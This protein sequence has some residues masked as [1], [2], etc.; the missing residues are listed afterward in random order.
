MSLLQTL[1]ADVE[2]AVAKLRTHL[3]EL[4]HDAEAEATALVEQ[5]KAAAGPVIQ[6][7]ED[8]AHDLAAEAV[9]D[10]KDVASSFA[11]GGVVSGPGTT[12]PTAP[13]EPDATTVQS[14]ATDA[15]EQSGATA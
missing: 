12:E 3:S 11:T 15:P 7:A 6:T 5:A 4:G 1:I 2:S 14:T 13:S 9:A 8:D 10:V